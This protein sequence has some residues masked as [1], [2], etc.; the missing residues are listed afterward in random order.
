MRPQT[1][2]NLVICL[3]DHAYEAPYANIK[4]KCQRW[5]EMPLLL[6]RSGT[7]YVA[8]VTKLL[9]SYCGALLVKSYYKE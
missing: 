6:G 3:L 9:S 5:P 2:A 7:H 8:M 1:W 4:M